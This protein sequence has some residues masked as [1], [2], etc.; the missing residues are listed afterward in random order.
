M[1]VR[2]AQRTLG[3]D[4]EPQAT[5]EARP[6][7]TALF[8]DAVGLAVAAF[9]NEYR[10]ETSIPYVTHLF[11]VVAL[12]GENGGDEEQL[13]AAILHDYL[14][15]IEGSSVEELRE[16]FGERVARLVRALSDSTGPKKRPWKERKE[17]YL[18]EL[19]QAPA[20]VK[21]IS[22]ADKLHNALSILRDRRRI[23][24]EVFDRF[25][26]SKTDTLWYY[27]GCVSALESNGWHSPLLDELREAVGRLVATG[28]RS[29]P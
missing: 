21:L 2:L 15:D 29:T 6:A 1:E 27:A 17:A 3:E 13:C 24:D 26:A 28:G 5:T 23:G 14:E 11:S 19:T 9:R 4:A 25:T 12:V 22:C 8:E 16:R 7:Y 18:E 10:K 20:E